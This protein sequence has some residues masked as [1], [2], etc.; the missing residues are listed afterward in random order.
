MKIG[1]IG[2]GLMGFPMAENVLNKLH[3]EK[4]VIWNRTVEKSKSFVSNHPE[5]KIA[6]NPSEVADTSD[7]VV[8]VLTDDPANEAV[9][10]DLLQTKN[11]S[12]TIVNMSTITPEKS[13]SLHNK[14]KEKGFRYIEAPVSGTIGPAKQGTLKIY[15][16][17]AKELN[18]ELQSLLLTMGDQ[19]FYIGEM[20]KATTIKLLINSNLA[21]YMSILS[22]T[23]LAGE[24]LGLDKEKFLNIIN[25]GIIATV[26]SKIK[27]PNVLKDN[28]STAFPFEHMLKD[29]TYSL[30]LLDSNKMPLV[31]VVKKQYEA[32]LESEKGKDFSAIFNYYSGLYK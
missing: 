12:L 2:L 11:N 13:I 14:A 1:F 27:G 20:G 16:G 19:V 26:A 15:T 7:V 30:S 17:G 6:S 10:N 3:P 32:V 28:F 21:V 29:M 8:L 23:L 18:D 25:G 9:M 4:F 24:K 31:D 22:E 5:V